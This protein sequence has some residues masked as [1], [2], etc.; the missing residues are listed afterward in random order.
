M[1]VDDYST[2]TGLR[3]RISSTST[4]TTVQLTAEEWQQLMEEIK[5]GEHDE[6]ALQPRVPFM[7]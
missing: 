5:A 7:Y 4:G 3:V 6:L 1:R 2:E